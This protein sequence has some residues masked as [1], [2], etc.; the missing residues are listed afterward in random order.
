MNPDLEDVVNRAA[1]R[2]GYG[3]P[4]ERL[5]RMAAART[6][7]SLKPCLIADGEPWIDSAFESND[8]TSAVEEPFV[9]VEI[10]TV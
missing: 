5:A 1:L 3:L 4:Q 6:L 7:L 2:S 10:I 9:A 8:A